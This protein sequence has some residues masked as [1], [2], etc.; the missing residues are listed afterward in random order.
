MDLIKI[1]DNK[2]KIMLTP[3]DM[4]CYA[5]KADELDGA[6]METRQAFRSIMDEVRHRTGFDAKGNQIYVQVYPSREGG[7]EM[8]VTKLGLLCALGEAEDR[9]SLSAAKGTCVAS[10]TRTQPSKQSER[11]RTIAFVF[12]ALDHLLHVC[13]RL[14]ARDYVGSSAVYRGEEGYFY[15]LLSESGSRRYA[16]S[17]RGVLAFLGEYGLQQNAEVVRLYIREHASPICESNAIERLSAL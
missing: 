8:F 15:L 14:H 7:C 6:K 13:R 11:N 9:P 2:L 3:G 17:D 10:T 5:L 12:E 16:L 1:N 4:Q